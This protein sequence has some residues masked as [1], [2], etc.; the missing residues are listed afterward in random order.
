[1]G[2]IVKVPNISHTILDEVSPS[3]NLVTSETFGPIAPIMRIDNI[4]DAVKVINSSEYK[5]A[6]AIMTQDRNKAVDFAN[7]IGVGQFNWN[8]PPGYRT[9]K[10]PFGGFGLSGN[11]LKEGVVDT[12]RNYR[13]IRTFY[14]H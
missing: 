1:M 3:S 5:L 2:T 7:E 8:G 12:V 13:K 4:R 14:T 10:A 9:E 11:G 6:G